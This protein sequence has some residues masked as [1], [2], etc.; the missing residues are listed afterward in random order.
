MCKI[1]MQEVLGWGFAFDEETIDRLYRQATESL[2]VQQP[3]SELKQ[4]F[5]EDFL[6]AYKRAGVNV[7]F[8]CPV[9]RS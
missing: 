6:Y 2:G 8:A 4:T 5:T 3:P 1:F 9:T 7:R